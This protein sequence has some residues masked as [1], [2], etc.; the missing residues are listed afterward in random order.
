MKARN[1]TRLEALAWQ[2][3]NPIQQ[4]F[5]IV[6]SGVTGTDAV[7]AEQRH[8]NALAAQRLAAYASPNT[9]EIRS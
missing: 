2:D 3:L 4:L 6:E 7:Y 5:R 1:M 9:P 8:R